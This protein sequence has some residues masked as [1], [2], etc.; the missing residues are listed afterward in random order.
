VLSSSAPAIAAG[1]PRF[2][3]LLAGMMALVFV[4]LSAIGRHIPRLSKRPNAL[5]VQPVPEVQ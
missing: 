4:S 1:S 5:G 2:F 3:M